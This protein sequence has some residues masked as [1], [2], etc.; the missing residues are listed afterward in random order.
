MSKRLRL[1]VLLLAA[2]M[3][4]E[5]V[6]GCGSSAIELEDY[7]D[8]VVATLGDYKIYL[9]EANYYARVD[10]YSTEYY[11]SYYGYDIDGLWETEISSSLGTYEDYSKENVM[12]IIYQTYVLYAKAEELGL[13]L[14]DA[15][16]ALIEEAVEDTM[17]A[18]PEI[19]VQVTLITSDRLYEI[20][21]VNA[22]AMKAYQY[23]IADVD[24]EVTDDEAAQRTIDYISIVVDDDDDEDEDDDLMTEEELAYYLYDL[25]DAGEEMSDELIE[26]YED[27]YSIYYYSLTYGEDDYTST[28]AETGLEMETDEYCVVYDEDNDYWYVIYCVT[29]FDEEATEEEKEE[30]IEE[31]EDEL[32]EEVYAEWV[33]DAG[34]FK[35]KEKIWA[36]VT[37]DEQVYG[38]EVE[39]DDEDE[40][41][42]ET[43]E[44]TEDETEEETEEETE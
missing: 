17:E 19:M 22:M 31:R 25:I 42:E 32:F 7:A 23:A 33:K 27:D 8:T 26:D 39:D 21:Y 34:N 15:E 30:I 9:D 41:E 14:S 4:M 16:I 5:S 11:Y 6:M 24:T 20:M 43:E 38:V 35:V 29:D 1:L 3:A 18:I 12:A 44:E 40:T 10:Q 36:L 13:E 37:Y 28:L 2:V